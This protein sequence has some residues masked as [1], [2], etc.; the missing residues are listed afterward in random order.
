MSTT[1]TQT[2]A[3]AFPDRNATGLGLE[4]TLA[5]GLSGDVLHL[6]G[7]AL[8]SSSFGRFL[9][10]PDTTSG[11]AVWIAG[12]LDASGDD[13]WH[14]DYNAA[15]RTL[16]LEAPQSSALSVALPAE[17]D[18]HGIEV[19]HDPGNDTMTL[20][21]NGTAI[22]TTS[23]PAA[24]P[25]AM[26]FWLGGLFKEHGVTG[27]MCF[28]EWIVAEQYIGPVVVTPDS[29]HA[30]DPARWLV[31]HNTADADSRAWAQTYAAARH[32]PYANRLGLD[33]PTDETISLSAYLAM[34]GE[35]EDYLDRNHLRPHI[36]GLLLGHRVPGY[37]DNDAVAQVHP[38]GSLLH[39]DGA[40][41]FSDNNPVG[42]L[43]PLTRPTA[44]NLGGVRLTA[45]LDGPTLD[46]TLALTTRANNIAAQTLPSTDQLWIDPIPETPLLAT[47]SQRL[48]KW[49]D[50]LDRQRLRLPLQISGDPA[51]Q[52][53]ADFSAIEHD[54][55]YWGWDNAT[56]PQPPE[57]FFTSPAGS[58]VVC[59][60][61]RQP[62]VEAT[63]LR[64]A[65]PTHWMDAALAGGYAAAIASSQS[66]S[67][68]AM[69]EAF[70][71]FE[72]LRR[73]WTLAEAW[74][75]AQPFVR[76]GM[77]L[78]GDPLL[79]VA[80]PRAGWDVFGPLQRIEELT[81]DT[82]TAA[83]PID[84]KRFELSA[85]LRPAEGESAAYLVRRLDPHGRAE[86]SIQPLPAAT[87]GAA[88]A[89]PPPVPAWPRDERWTLPI[90]SGQ[91]VAQL[92]LPAKDPSRS[93]H[94]IELLND[95]GGD[96]LVVSLSTFDPLVQQP[97]ALTA[98]TTRYRWR[99][100]SV[101]GVEALT[102]WSAPQQLNDAELLSLTSLER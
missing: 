55:F 99:L 51:T 38:M 19:G 48:M 101:E 92:I 35:I 81:P 40:G 45:R 42:T 77:Y 96:P 67:L 5:L 26:Q 63:T 37:V 78:V 91:A 74:V 56:P 72:A 31:I 65:T 1:L 60:Q 102:P 34:L 33:L 15:D 36:L 24:T 89:V 41:L 27:R 83:L 69:P 68:S 2:H 8:P 29:D 70:R 73:G 44:D 28:D 97:V 4:A 17:S 32:I 11:G 14:I 18:W 90:R 84:T 61:L 13:A 66:T 47:L 71:F 30:D 46:D 59:A 12:A 79:T 54:A 52:P 57:A 21:V 20:W 95:Q 16:T 80:T 94:S 10:K 93:L 43:D 76:G 53:D 100:I 82:P 23:L 39:T 6:D 62:D 9:F 7:S 49:V 88:P 64:S 87:Q 86:A 85:A 3:A 75:V 98:T 50:G 25:Q 22:G 58:R